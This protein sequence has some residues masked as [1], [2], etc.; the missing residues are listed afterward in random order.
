MKE[1]SI[2]F[3]PDYFGESSA[4]DNDNSI[5]RPIAKLAMLTSKR[6]WLTQMA[7]MSGKNEC[8]TFGN[9]KP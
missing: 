9:N 7:S 6:K 5:G 4:A 3:I 2:K 8:A 1:E